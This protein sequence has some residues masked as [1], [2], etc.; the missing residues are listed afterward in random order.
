MEKITRVEWDTIVQESAPAYSGYWIKIPAIKIV[1]VRLSVGLRE[2]KDI[3]DFVIKEYKEKYANATYELYEA[4]KRLDSIPATPSPTV[5]QFFG[6]GK[7]N[8]PHCKTEIHVT[9]EESEQIVVPMTDYDSEPAEVEDGVFVASATAALEL[10]CLKKYY[11]NE[12]KL[13]GDRIHELI[14]NLK[15]T[16]PDL[17][18]LRHEFSR[19]MRQQEGVKFDPTKTVKIKTAPDHRLHLKLGIVDGDCPA[20]GTEMP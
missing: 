20:C 9:L 7:H 5:F 19:E 16:G 15:L 3:V 4:D 1:R 2:A 18:K 13:T 11:R 14:K 6:Q 12:I 10:E 17:D 8:C